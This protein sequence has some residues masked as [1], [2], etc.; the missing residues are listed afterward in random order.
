MKTQ[1]INNTLNAW[2]ASADVQ[3]GGDRP[4]DLQVHDNRFYARVLAQGSLGL[5]ESYMAG[6]WDCAHLDQFFNRI[7]RVKLHEK[8]SGL[9]DIWSVIKSK[10]I[11]LQKPSRA[12]TIGRKHYDIGNT[13]FQKMLDKRMIYSC[14][15]WR[16][17]DNI[18]Q[19]QEHKLDLVCR[20]LG[21]EPGMRVLDIGCGWGGTA[22]FAAERYG[23]EV[24]GLTVSKKQKQLA[25]EFCRDWPIDIRLQDYRDLNETFDRIFSIGMFEHV[26]YK[27]YADYFQVVKKNLR[28]D[29]L[30][31][32][33]CIGGNHSV[34]QTDPWIAKY[35]FPNSMIPSVQQ[36]AEN[37]EG[38]LVLE[39]WHNFGVDYDTTLMA[40]Y[41]NFNNSWDE[42]KQDYDDLFYRQWCYYLL[43][44][45]GS[46][47]ARSNQLWQCVFSKDGLPGGYQSIR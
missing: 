7:L 18:N 27:N 10:I 17:A 11:N 13:L 34:T 1:T 43:S 4:W 22:R 39:D 44:C 33:H 41:E 32:L 9:G 16:F 12:F 35:I 45:A 6:W 23:V 47:R 36:I 26:G 37:T 2:L 21:L 19:A 42:I 3:I 30:F 25:D 20:K 14:G 28:D 5:G 29:G 31:L 15:Y 8:V 38:L 24:V 40:W 46:F